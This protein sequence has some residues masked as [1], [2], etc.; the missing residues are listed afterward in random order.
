VLSIIKQAAR[1]KMERLEKGLYAKVVRE[2]VP[3]TEMRYY[4]SKM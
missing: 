4:E 1:K 2:G 3:E